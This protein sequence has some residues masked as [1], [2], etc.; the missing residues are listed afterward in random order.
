MIDI[1]YITPS[2]LLE[3]KGEDEN[4]RC[5]SCEVID[6]TTQEYQ[7]KIKDSRHT[8]SSWLCEKCRDK[9]FSVGEM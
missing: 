1:K 9:K 5:D 7:V 4:Y 8:Y 3:P 2:I 6:I